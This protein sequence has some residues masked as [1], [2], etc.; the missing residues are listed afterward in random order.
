MTKANEILQEEIAATNM[1]DEIKQSDDQLDI[2]KKEI[3]LFSENSPS[4]WD[5]PSDNANTSITSSPTETIRTSKNPTAKI[6]KNKRMER[7][8]I[9]IRKSVHKVNLPPSALNLDLQKQK[10]FVKKKQCE[11][12]VISLYNAAIRGKF[13]GKPKEIGLLTE[14]GKI[15]L[16]KL[17][18]LK[19]R[20]KVSFVLNPSDLCHINGDHWGK[21]KD[22]GN[23]I[24]L[25]IKDIRNLIYILMSPDIVM[26]F[27]D[28]YSRKSFYLLKNNGNGTYNIDEIYA[29]RNGN[30][31]LKTMYKTKKSADQRVMDLTS[32]LS[33]S[34][35]YSAV[36]SSDAKIP[37]LF[38]CASENLEN[39][40]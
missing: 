17:S 10:N 6:I 36:N 7:H 3:G 37:I 23:N 22:E 24:P 9:I 18:G 16:E 1:I 34:G 19:L 39:I 13:Y 38:Q 32:L 25:E 15:F 31:T 33:T 5:S 35:T 12:Y 11:H 21:E 20:N 40:K 2:L 29:S 27:N 26:Y 28:K 14:S 4:Y 8:S 30:L